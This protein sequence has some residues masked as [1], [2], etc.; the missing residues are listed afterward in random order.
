MHIHDAVN[1]L[2]FILQGDPALQGAKIIAEVKI[3]CW[4]CAGENP[5]FKG[6]HFTSILKLVE[7]RSSA[8][9]VLS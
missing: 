8:I 7:S 6:V 2:F 4:L 1:A 9:I 5:F 3:A